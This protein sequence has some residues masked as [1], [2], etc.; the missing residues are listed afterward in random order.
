MN[1]VRLYYIKYDARDD[2]VPLDKKQL[3]RWL[4]ELS[5]QKREAVE[6][7]I[8]SNDRIMSLLASQ[9][10]KLCARDEAIDD[11]CLADVVYPETGKPGWQSKQG[12]VLDFNVSHSNACVVV[13]VSRTVRVG[14]DVEKIRQLKNLNFKMVM[15][16]DELKLIGETPALF[17]ELWSKKEAVV[18]A[19]NTSGISRMRDVVLTGNRAVLAGAYWHLREINVDDEF[20]DSYEIYLATS[21]PVDEFKIK[22]ICIDEL[23]RAS[24]DD[25]EGNTAA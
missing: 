17:F 1:S 2:L 5:M 25:Q 19:A 3:E 14:V 7:L 21:E 22:C 4:S 15:L 18:K 23:I 24:G 8:N 20:D 11:F 10:I 9:L 13:A 6:R 16:P 12:S